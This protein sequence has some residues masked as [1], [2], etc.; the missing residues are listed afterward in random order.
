MASRL[1]RAFS[2]ARSQWASMGEPSPVGKL[3]TSHKHSSVSLGTLGWHA[4]PASKLTSQIA[5][6]KFQK[7]GQ[8]IYFGTP[9]VAA[10]FGGREEDSVILLVGGSKDAPTDV[11]DV[12]GTNYFVGGE[13][14]DVYILDAHEVCPKWKEFVTNPDIQPTTY[15]RAS[16]SWETFVAELTK[17]SE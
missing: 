6:G 9:K 1:T 14:Q 2:A 4:G 12:F 15:E 16:A 5:E 10:H 7:I 11:N 3:I 13:Q 17:E 8:D